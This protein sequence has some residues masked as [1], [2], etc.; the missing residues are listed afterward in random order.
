MEIING[1][2]L[3]FTDLHLGLKSGS[4]SRLV[5]CINV[6]K[7]II[8]YIK[9]NEIKTCLFLGDWHHVRTSTD[10]NVLNVSYKLMSALAKHCTVYCL[11]GNHDIYMKNTVDINSLVFFN[12]IKNV[13]LISETTEVSINGNKS[14]LVPWLGDISKFDKHFFDMLFG[15]FDISTKY[16][17]KSYIE[18]HSLKNTCNTQTRNQIENDDLLST[19][20]NQQSKAGDFIGDFVDI[21]KE[22]GV[23]FS[24]HIHGQKEFLS[25]GRKFIFVGDPYQQ[26]LGEKNNDCGF[27]I[28]D[29]DNSY[30]FHPILNV[31]K[32]VELKMS[33]IIKD[34]DNYDFRKVNGNIVH[35]IYDIDVDNLTDAKISQKINDYQPYEELLPDYEVD[36]NLCNGDMQMQN[37]SIELIKK[38]KLEYVKNYVMN[39]DKNVLNEQGLESDKL[40]SVLSEYYNL[41]AEEK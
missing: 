1:K 23:I 17:I 16:L 41:V 39:I 13:K 35:K 21:V 2:V 24:G 32:H 7:E 9:E 40:F 38:S 15:H 33:E 25:K 12:T 8:K 19:S 20:L 11:L 29:S 14:C 6:I 18:E 28:I 5:I 4:K 10:N 31:P 37:A 30:S 34:I 27:Y 36:L 26:N 3:V 22:S